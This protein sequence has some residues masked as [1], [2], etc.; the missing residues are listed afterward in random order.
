MKNA[1]PIEERIIIALDLASVAKTRDWLALLQPETRFFKIGLE[2]FLAGGWQI[3]EEIQQQHSRVML[4]LKLLDIPNTVERAVRQ[5]NNRRLDL[6]TVHAASAAAALAGRQGSNPCVLAVTL[7][8]S[9]AVDGQ[10]ARELTLRRAESALKAGCD[11][12]V[13]APSEAAALRQEFG[14]DF[15]L[16]TPGIR[17]RPIDDDQQRT[18]GAREA[19]SAGADYLVVG[20]PI[21][22]APD[23]LAAL[24]RMK[25]RVEDAC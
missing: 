16:V 9:V 22:T 11:G 12:L 10:A 7:L 6:I 24:R 21:L 14:Q 4:D 5:L 8:T 13:A 2:L 3:I 19:I 17:D 20:R 15:I 1:I 18:A 25:Q 23:P